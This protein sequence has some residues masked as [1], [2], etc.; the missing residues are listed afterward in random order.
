M[1]AIR[2][3]LKKIPGVGDTKQI[4]L[5]GVVIIESGKIQAHIPGEINGKIFKKQK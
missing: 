3:G 2:S 4:G 1:K 5:G